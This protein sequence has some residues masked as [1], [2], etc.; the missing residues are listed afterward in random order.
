MEFITVPEEYKNILID[1]L[2]EERAEPYIEGKGVSSDRMKL[3][4]SFLYFSKSEGGYFKVRGDENF[5]LLKQI[6]ENLTK[7]LRAIEKAYEEEN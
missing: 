3:A 6:Y 7:Q 4:G 5:N 2:L 1:A